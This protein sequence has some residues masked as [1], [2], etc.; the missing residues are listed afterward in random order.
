M[1][2]EL[3]Q[4]AHLQLDAAPQFFLITRNGDR[5]N[6]AGDISL[7]DQATVLANVAKA[8]G[9]PFMELQDAFKEVAR[10]VYATSSPR[11]K[12]VN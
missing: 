4:V 6:I 7:K 5:L 2:P 11:I 8:L 12:N 3:K 10:E 1:N 9:M